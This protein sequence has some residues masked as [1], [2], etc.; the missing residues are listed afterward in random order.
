ML[1]T[2]FEQDIDPSASLVIVNPHRA[3]IFTAVL[4]AIDVGETGI[5]LLN[6]E[7]IRRRGSWRHLEAEKFATLELGRLV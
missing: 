1:D 4:A 2:G 5:G 3:P 7:I 6:R